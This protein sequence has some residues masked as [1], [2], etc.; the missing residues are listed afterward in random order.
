MAKLTKR[1]RL[2]RDKVDS[3]KEY[4]INEAVAL[5]KELATAKFA[6]SEDVSANLGLDAKKSD[7]KVPGETV[8]P[9]GTGQ[10]VLDAAYT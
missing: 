1:A 3:T 7:Q 5:L 4:E 2:V 9:N 8:E 6:E 10:H